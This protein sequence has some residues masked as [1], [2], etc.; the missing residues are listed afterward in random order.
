MVQCRNSVLE[1]G[2]LQRTRDVCIYLNTG[3]LGKDQEMR[4][5][6]RGSDKERLGNEE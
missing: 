5:R 1:K 4:E 2:K 6:E 3:I